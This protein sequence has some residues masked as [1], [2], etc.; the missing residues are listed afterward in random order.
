[1][2]NAKEI[3]TELKKG[4]GLKTDLELARFLDVSPTTISTWKS[5]NSIDYKMIIPL[6]QKH[7]IDLNALF[8]GEKM[9]LPPNETPFESLLQ[10]LTVEIEKRLSLK[11]DD[12]KATNELIYDLLE[13]ED[14]KRKID[15][16]K[17]K[18]SSKTNG[19][20]KSQ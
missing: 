17:S 10:L 1:M 15:A 6:C 8:L 2:R 19:T 20:T 7:Q 12:I 14:V 5:R 4:F 11:L 9:E 3:I 13:K 18:M 16:A